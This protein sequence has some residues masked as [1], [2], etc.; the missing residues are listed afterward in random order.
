[1]AELTLEKKRALALADVRARALAFGRE[2][3]ESQPGSPEIMEPGPRGEFASPRRQPTASEFAGRGIATAL[4]APMDAA[5]W[6]DRQLGYSS[7]RP[8]LGSARIA[9]FMRNFAPVAGE[10]ETPETLGQSAAEGLGLAGGSLLPGGGVTGGLVKYGGPVA[11]GVGK[12]IAA[13]FIKTPARATALELTAGA[14]AG[15]GGLIAEREARDSGLN[16]DAARM[17]GELTGGLVAALA[18]GAAVSG[19]VKAVR[20]LPLATFSRTLEGVFERGLPGAGP[21]HGPRI[22]FVPCQATPRRTRRQLP[23]IPSRA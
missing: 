18:P 16:S 7:D 19:T 9:D 10:H 5:A 4:G 22:G 11:R 12:T 3:A 14:G 15:A 17:V 21:S 2:A 13:P 6:V 20:A 1:M 8:L 23:G